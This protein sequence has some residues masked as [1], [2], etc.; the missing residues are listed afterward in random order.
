MQAPEP[1]PGDDL[2]SALRDIILRPLKTLV[3]PWS[4]KA[5]TLSAALRAAAFF[6]NNLRA[7]RH[8]AVRAMIVEAV[9]A[10]FAAGLIGA[11][12]QRLRASR[13][14]W[15]TAIVVCLLAPGAM[16]IAQLAVHRAA[17]T[18]HV[19]AGVVS[20][21][22]LAAIASAYSWYAMRYGA[23]LGGNDSTSLGHDLRSLPGISLNFVL[24]V[25]RSVRRIARAPGST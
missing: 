17:H 4:W 7:G 19:G 11:V 3:P 5:A 1:P 25:P 21:F 6:A 24:A 22:C 15:A 9:F 2:K 16:V 10:V 18:P 12:S 8:R 13:P 23:L 14:V 20:S